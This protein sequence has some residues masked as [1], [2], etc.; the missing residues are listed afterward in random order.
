[1]KQKSVW[2]HPVNSHDL[3]KNVAE[4]APVVVKQP[5][6]QSLI[7]MAGQPVG[8]LWARHKNRNAIRRDIDQLDPLADVIVL[9]VFAQAGRHPQ[10]GINP[11]F[12]SAHQTI[13]SSIETQDVCQCQ[14]PAPRVSKKP[15]RALSLHKLGEGGSREVI[16][17]SHSVAAVSQDRNALPQIGPRQ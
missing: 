3:D 7:A 2:T 12:S 10:W 14:D 11:K 9:E 4:H 1:M 13:R 8:G 6:G 17:K 5:R 16:D 15:L